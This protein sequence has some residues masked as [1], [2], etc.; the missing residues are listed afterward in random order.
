MRKNK[1]KENR[2]GGSLRGATWQYQLLLFMSP[3]WVLHSGD[4]SNNKMDPS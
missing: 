3:K 2:R 4:I 1:I